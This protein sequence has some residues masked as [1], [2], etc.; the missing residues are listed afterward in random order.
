MV[1][2]LLFFS[3]L[4]GA[5]QALFINGVVTGL[6]GSKPWTPPAFCH[7]LECPKYSVVEKYDNFERR[8]YEPSTWVATKINT[9]S[10]TQA[11]TTEMFFK[12][13]HYISGNNTAAMKIPMTAPV[14]TEV[15]N[16]S[17][18]DPS[19]T[20]HFF[21]PF[22]LQANPPKPTESGVFIRQIPAMDVYVRSF[23][24]FAN[25]DKYADEGAK[26]ANDLAAANKLFQ[27]MSIEYLTAGYDGPYAFIRHN[28]VWLVAM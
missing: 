16:D 19:V 8:H 24:G 21:M 3:L 17:S 23:G 4:C 10:Y 2:T 1:G 15:A 27:P 26:L 9:P 6:D 7:D 11:Q 14:V 18:S 22:N 25:N 5:T 28:E 12:L 13:F 20:M